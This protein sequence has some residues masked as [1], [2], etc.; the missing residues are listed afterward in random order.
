MIQA[1]HSHTDLFSTSKIVCSFCLIKQCVPGPAGPSTSHNT[2]EFA[3]GRRALAS[4]IHYG[5]AIV[6]RIQLSQGTMPAT[7]YSYSASALCPPTY[8]CIQLSEISQRL[9]S[10]QTYQLTYGH[11]NNSIFLYFYSAVQVN[12]TRAMRSCVS[13][14]N[15]N[16]CAHLLMGLAIIERQSQLDTAETRT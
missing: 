4:G 1:H 16:R 6:I 7:D 12:H 11:D 3:M 10:C 8:H 13:L 15:F 5:Q 14:F 2:E 9:G